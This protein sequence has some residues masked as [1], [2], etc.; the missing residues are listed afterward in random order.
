MFN[1]RVHLAI[2]VLLCSVPVTATTFL[3]P[4]DEEAIAAA[5]GIVTGAVEGSYPREAHSWVE[6][7]YQIRVQ[8][9]LKGEFRAAELIDVVSPGGWYGDHGTIAEGAAQFVQGEH[10]LLLLRR[11]EGQLEPLDFALGKFR[12]VTAE[13]G[14]RLLLRDLENAAAFDSSGKPHTEKVRREQEFIRFIEDRVTG[15]RRSKAGDDYLIDVSSVGFPRSEIERA[16]GVRAEIDPWTGPSYGKAFACPDEAFGCTPPNLHSLRFPGTSPS[17][18]MKRTNALS[19][20]GDGGESLVIAG[21]A[22]WTNDCGSA[23]TLTYGGTTSLTKTSDTNHTTS[24]IEFNDPRGELSS[25][26]AGFTTSQF[27]GPVQSFD[28]QLWWV[29]DDSDIVINNNITGASISR[30]SVMTHEIGHAIGFRHS[31]GTPTNPDTNLHVCNSSNEECVITPTAIMYQQVDGAGFGTTLQPYD[32]HAVGALYAGGS[33]VTVGTP[34]NLVATPVGGAQVHVSWTAATDATGYNVYRKA[35][36]EGSFTVLDTTAG[37]TYDDDSV[38]SGQAYLYRVSATAGDDESP[39]SNQ[40]FA[41]VYAF[42][43]PTITVEVTTVKKAHIDQLRDCVNA[44][45]ALAGLGDETWTTDPTIISGST[46][47]KR[48]HVIELREA[49][50]DARFALGFTGATFATDASIIS[51]TTEIKKA[52]IDE[53]RNAVK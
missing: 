37:T 14:E 35:A 4:S 17:V 1:L 38:S 49:I 45:R 46:Q 53:L 36:D 52:H 34:S 16:G 22:A 6:T 33:C 24:T 15:Q 19:G 28:G 30:Q 27:S 2:A 48:E 20:A 43:D 51:G 42:T 8:R 41:T 7:V 44:M 47:A 31:N 26:L 5:G 32:V 10:V 18:T 12:F 9:V 25:G 11:H 39:Q 23:I 21:L 40:D 29:I 3:I 50:N 13:T